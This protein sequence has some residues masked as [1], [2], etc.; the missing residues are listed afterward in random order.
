MG[1][2]GEFTLRVGGR[3]LDDFCTQLAHYDNAWYG[4]QA[5]RYPARECKHM[6]QEI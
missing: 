5:G 4:E 1:I 3:A 2:R 6:S